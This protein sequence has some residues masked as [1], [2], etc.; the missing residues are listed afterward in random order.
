[1]NV[2]GYGEL[3]TILKVIAKNSLYADCLDKWNE[4]L[5]ENRLNIKQFNKLWIQF[6]QR[7]D[8]CSKKEQKQADKKCNNE[9]SLK[10]I[11]CWDFENPNL[12][13]LKQFLKNIGE[14]NDNF[15]RN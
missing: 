10:K 8:C 7:Y 6:Y 15:T 11:D 9:V 14:K 13:E 5:G 3:E 4:C 12:N 1:M 2:D